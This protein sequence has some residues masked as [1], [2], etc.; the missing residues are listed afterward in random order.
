LVKE[1]KKNVYSRFWIF[2]RDE[3]D[4]ARRERKGVALAKLF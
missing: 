1:G 2:N 3:E 4:A